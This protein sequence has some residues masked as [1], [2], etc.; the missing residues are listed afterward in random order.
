MNEHKQTSTQH[1]FKKRKETTAASGDTEF[2]R[3]HVLT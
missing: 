1:R 2:I 3:L